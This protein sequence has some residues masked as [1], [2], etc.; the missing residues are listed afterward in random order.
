M[1][2][3][4]ADIIL[5]VY[6]QI[7][8]SIPCLFLY[9]SVHCD[10]DEVR[11]RNIFVRING[12]YIPPWITKN[13]TLFAC[14]HPILTI[15]IG[16]T[17]AEDSLLFIPEGR[18]SWLIVCVI[19]TCFIINV[20]L[21]ISWKVYVV[22]VQLACHMWSTNLLDVELTKENELGGCQILKLFFVAPGWSCL[23]YTSSI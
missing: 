8:R 12:H 4:S 19:F 14:Y 16:Y 6:L 21:F 23:I 15:N 18:I 22:F 13:L 1:F 11:F 5:L 2:Y 7:H 17:K 3:L 10:D 9:S 20:T